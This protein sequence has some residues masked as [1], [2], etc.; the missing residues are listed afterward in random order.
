METRYKKAYDFI[1]T[2]RVLLSLAAVSYIVFWFLR[3]VDFPLIPYIAPIFEPL[4]HL[5]RHKIEWEMDFEG[6]MV[7]MMPLAAAGVFWIGFVVLQPLFGIIDQME[8]RHKLNVIAERKLQEKLVNENLKEI[9]KNKTMEYS[10]FAILLGLE[11]Q[12]PQNSKDINREIVKK[13]YIKIVNLI[14]QKYAAAKLI[15]P[16]K[17]FIT[18]NNFA[19]FD[20]FL[21]DILFEIKQFSKN[22]AENGAEVTFS[23][24]IDAL[25]ET[26]KVANTFDLLEKISTFSYTNRAIATSSF[27]IRYNLNTGQNQYNLE[28]M[29]ISRFFENSGDKASKSIDFELF[30]LKSSKAKKK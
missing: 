7:D 28:T 27:N 19:L 30:S 4:L 3:F 22:M 21:R 25:K 12:A 9:F 8:H 10:K 2:V 23:I 18:Y 14:R 20:D 1:G 16:D 26:D 24:F 13:E 17:L 11:L 15:M 29:G 5:L 6:K